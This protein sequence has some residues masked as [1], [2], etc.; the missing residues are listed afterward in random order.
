[1]SSANSYNDRQRHRTKRTVSAPFGIQVPS[2][3]R[4]PTDSTFAPRQLE[5][6]KNDDNAREV[7]LQHLHDHEQFANVW[8][9]TKIHP[10]TRRLMR[11]V[12]QIQTINAVSNGYKQ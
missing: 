5:T 7:A 11:K 3:L 8:S 10:N 1:M 12:V 4:D 6:L 9:S 2:S